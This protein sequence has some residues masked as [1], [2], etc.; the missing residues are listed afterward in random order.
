MSGYLYVCV[1]ESCDQLTGVATVTGEL[2][3]GRGS[4]ARPVSEE[5]AIMIGV[6]HL[7]LDVDL[8]EGALIHV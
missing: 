7:F 2:L 3:A 5:R 6:A 8:P 4:G 1:V